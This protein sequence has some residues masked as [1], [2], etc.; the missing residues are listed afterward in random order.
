MADSRQMVGFPS[1]E[2][3]HMWAEQFAGNKL[4]RILYVIGFSDG[5][6]IP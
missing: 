2:Q 4:D 3:A 6:F 1:P 5:Q